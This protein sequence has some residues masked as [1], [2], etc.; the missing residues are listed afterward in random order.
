M[1]KADKEFFCI[2][3]QLTS[4]WEEASN[5]N[6]M[7]TD[8]EHLA[9]D[10]TCKANY[11]TQKG[12][13]ISNLPQVLQDIDTSM[14]FWKRTNHFHKKSLEQ[15]KLCLKRALLLKKKISQKWTKIIKYEIFI[16][17]HEIKHSELMYKDAQIMKAFV[18]RYDQ[19][20]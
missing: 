9:L 14:K 4:Y 15:Y 18:Q 1:A 17:T 5:F 2:D 10:Y 6:I 13:Q 11:L 3:P 7:A 20:D 19:N 8:N 16:L 12:W